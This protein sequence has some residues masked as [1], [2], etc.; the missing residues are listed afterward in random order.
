VHAAG[1]NRIVASSADAISSNEGIGRRGGGGSRAVS[2]LAGSAGRGSRINATSARAR[3]VESGQFCS[4]RCPWRRAGPQMQPGRTGAEVERR[5]VEPRPSR[6]RGRARGK[7]ARVGGRR[8]S[9]AIGTAMRPVGCAGSCDGGGGACD[10]EIPGAA[11]ESTEKGMSAMCAAAS[12]TG[13]IMANPA[14]AAMRTKRAPR[15]KRHMTT[16]P[17][18]GGRSGASDAPSSTS[19]GAAASESVRAA[20]AASGF[21]AATSSSAFQASWRRSGRNPPRSNADAGT[22]GAPREIERI[23][24]TVAE[25]PAGERAATADAAAAAAGGIPTAVASTAVNTS[26][27]GGGGWN[28]GAVMSGR[29][30]ETFF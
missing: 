17:A 22:K 15:R 10:A 8:G 3:T 20:A 7:G 28:A 11:K 29:N 18:I 1:S 21:A 14:Q 13:A 6:P 5:A 27:L 24:A 9:W 23:A 12:E 30:S 25:K 16:L 2:T 19:A 4:C 26:R